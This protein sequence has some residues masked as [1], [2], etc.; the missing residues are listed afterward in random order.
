MSWGTVSCELSVVCQKQEQ[1][2]A[3]SERFDRDI[4]PNGTFTLWK[5]E[6]E[7]L[8]LYLDLVSSEVSS[9]FDEEVLSLYDWFRENFSLS[10]EG[11]WLFEGDG[12]WRCEVKDGKVIDAGLD[13]LSGYTVE[14]INELRELAETKFKTQKEG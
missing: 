4:L 10:V 5:P 9:D 13:W 1:V 12:N 3:V 7:P 2:N 6:H 8:K 14:Q 11:Y